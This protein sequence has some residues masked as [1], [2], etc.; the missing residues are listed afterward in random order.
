MVKISLSWAKKKEKKQY[1]KK[2]AKQI[3][4]I[5]SDYN[6]TNLKGHSSL[7]SGSAGM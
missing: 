2:A 1:L 6:A 5:Y 4:H 3:M 7:K